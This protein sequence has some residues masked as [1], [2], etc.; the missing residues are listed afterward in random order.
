MNNGFDDGGVAFTIIHIKYER[1]VDLDFIERQPL[2]I[3]KGLKARTKIV[4]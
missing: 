4:N 1:L 2:Q 3:S